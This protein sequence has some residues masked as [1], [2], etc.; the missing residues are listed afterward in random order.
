ML[1]DPLFVDQMTLIQRLPR[2]NSLGENVL[3]ESCIQSYGTIQPVSGRTVQR[4]PD[5]LRVAN[6][7]S[8]WFKGEIVAS[9]PGQYTS[10]LVFRGKRYQVQLVFDWGNW[11]SGWCEGVAVAEVPA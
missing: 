11:G 9:A 6:V 7:S 5:S 8:F 1:Q 4:L 10:V 3:T 2:L